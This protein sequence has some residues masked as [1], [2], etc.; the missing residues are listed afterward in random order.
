MYW[1]LLELIKDILYLN[2][3][4]KYSYW[5]DKCIS[6]LEKCKKYRNKHSQYMHLSRFHNKAVDWRFFFVEAW[7]EKI[8]LFGV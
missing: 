5:S 8:S 2:P 1:P 6:Y 7:K 4:H 3:T